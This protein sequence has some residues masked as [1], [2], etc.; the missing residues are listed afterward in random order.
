MVR[1]Q[2]FQWENHSTK[3]LTW[4]RNSVWWAGLMLL[5]EDKSWNGSKWNI[6][7]QKN[8]I[9]KST[10]KT[11]ALSLTTELAYSKVNAKIN[12]SPRYLFQQ[13]WKYIS[14]VVFS[15]LDEV[16][17]IN[18]KSL[19]VGGAI[20]CLWMKLVQFWAN[21][22]TSLKQTPSE[23]IRHQYKQR[24]ALSLDKPVTKTKFSSF[25]TRKNSNVA[26]SNSKLLK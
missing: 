15:W 14:F 13:T 6:F 8:P 20:E 21:L 19:K 4:S 12:P 5:G 9:I 22:H 26:N 17:F 7:D 16:I 3:V 24:F 18:Y 23:T 11:T 2:S 25:L 1:S 10:W